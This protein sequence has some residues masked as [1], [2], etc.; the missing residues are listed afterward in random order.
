MSILSQV[1]AENT[2][3]ET[4]LMRQRSHKRQMTAM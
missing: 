3:K 1:I 4:R 2:R